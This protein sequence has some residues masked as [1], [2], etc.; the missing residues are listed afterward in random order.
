MVKIAGYSIRKLTKC[1]QL[2]ASTLYNA[3]KSVMTDLHEL[4]NKHGKEPDPILLSLKVIKVGQIPSRPCKA[5]IL[6]KKHLFN[7]NIWD[8][9]KPWDKRDATLQ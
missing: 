4:N 6:N 3:V 8:M 9:G 1:S 7:Y 2:Y 5:L